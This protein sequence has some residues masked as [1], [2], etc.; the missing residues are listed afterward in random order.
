MVVEILRPDICVIGAGSG[1]LT[2][3]AA[4]KALGGSVVL[5]EA[6][7]MG[8]DCLNY[9]CV[10]SKA[11]IAAA[12]RA[13]TIAHSF[14]FGVFTSDLKVNFGRVHE[15]VQAT[16]KAIAPNDSA[17]RFEA[18]GVKLIRDHARFINKSCV[19]AGDYKIKARRFVI[20]TG[21]SPAIPALKGLDKIDYLTNET[22]FE[23]TRKPAHLIII[24]AGATGM[25]LAQAHKRLGCE[26]SVIEMFD[27]LAKI[28]PELSRIA[29]RRIEAEGVKIYS[30][31]SVEALA[32]A[33]NGISVHMKSGDKTETIGGSHLLLATG[34]TANINDLGLEEARIKLNGGAIRVNK[35]MKTS[36]RRVYAIGDVV[37]GLQ[38][39]HVASYQAGLVTRNALFGLPASHNPHIIPWAIYTDPEIAQVGIGETEAKQRF[40]ANFKVMRANFA[41]NDRSQAENRP[42]GLVK[43]IADNKGRILGAAI[44]GAN[45]GE[46]ISFFA[47]AIANK[48]KM[49][50]LIRFVAPYP[51]LSEIVKRLGT[52][53]YS[54]KLDSFW[55]GLLRNFNRLLP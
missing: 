26:V 48:M 23:L 33:R 35:G 29:L 27:P 11:L 43:L 24:G 41:Q 20:A 45:A 28:E 39:T 17:E 40:G 37:G 50:S 2:V 38:F 49:A 25:E 5:I 34:R 19:V 55:L 10:P 32:P 42:E 30:R 3:A 12:K 46:L 47:Y 21:S 13:H 54:D 52:A 8:G 36:N 22:I 15:H 9:G 53:F 16:I 44:V 14:R 6:G 31:T 1:G 4:T 7:K 51:T 18:L